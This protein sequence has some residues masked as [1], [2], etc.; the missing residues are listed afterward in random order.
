MAARL[1]AGQNVEGGWSYTCPLVNA[2]VLTN[3]AEMPEPPEGAGD[4]SC[5][6][7]AVL[8]LWISSRWGVNIDDTMLRVGERFTDQQME[9]GGWAYNY[10]A[11]NAASGNSMT[12]AGLFCLTVAKA[13]ELRKMQERERTDAE[14]GTE[15]IDNTSGE[16]LETDPVFARGLEKAGGFAAGISAGQARYFLWSVERL[17]V[18][19]EL[20]TIGTTDWFEKGSN[21]LSSS[22]SGRTGHGS[23][24]TPTGG[25]SPTR[26]SP[27]CFYARRTWEAISRGC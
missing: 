8:G 9:D 24:A 12:F 16:P 21:A 23:T 4:N 7:F 26:P 11:E 22:R 25:T 13:T 19:L 15:R 18:L 20:E 17:G 6:Q 14:S 5:T 10:A 27:F 1:I 3:S 2:I